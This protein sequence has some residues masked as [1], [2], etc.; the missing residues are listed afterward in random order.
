MKFQ[1][2]DR[3]RFL[4]SSDGGEIIR[5]LDKNRLVVKTD[6][7]F[8]FTVDEANVVKEVIP[9]EYEISI[10]EQEKFI[11]GKVLS[12]FG[13]KKRKKPVEREMEIDLHIYELVD[14]TRNMTNGEILQ[15]QVRF[16][17]RKLQEAIEKRISKVIFIHGVGEGVLRSEI[18]HYLKG[19]ENVEIIDGDYRKYGAGAT[20][21]RLWYK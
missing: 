4:D 18:R 21:V 5:L 11:R 2:G 1:P 9:D 3:I 20:E 6:H 12:D 15:I 7:G 8:E 10:H 14:S 13:R 19:I 16:F 17:K